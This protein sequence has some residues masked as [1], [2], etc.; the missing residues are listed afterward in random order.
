MKLT[1]REFTVLAP[2]A[3]AGYALQRFDLGAAIVGTAAAEL[4]TLTLAD[5]LESPPISTTTSTRRS[6]APCRR[7]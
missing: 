3:L 6:R 4:T 2:G 7:R 5:V 1:R